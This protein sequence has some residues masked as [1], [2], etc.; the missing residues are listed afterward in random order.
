MTRWML[1]GLALL[2]GCGKSH[3]DALVEIND[4]VCVPCHR[5]EYEGAQNPLHVGVMP[6][7]CADCHNTRA[8][9]PATGGTHPED[10]FSITTPPHT[11][12]CN[13]CHN[14]SLGLTP[15]KDNTDCIGCHTGA[16]TLV[17]MDAAHANV[18]AYLPDPSM[19]HFC[20]GCHPAGR[21]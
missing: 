17:L 9:R 19:P 18:A 10:R 4:G 11:F 15:G 6:E 1:L 20:L 2:A 12:A 14:P 8:W 13:E 3:A 21:R 7:T 5:D 16:H